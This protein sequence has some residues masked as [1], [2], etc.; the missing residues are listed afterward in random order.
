MEQIQI[1][2]F[3]VE[4][5]LEFIYIAGLHKNA[6]TFAKALGQEVVMKKIRSRYKNHYPEPKPNQK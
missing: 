5:F 2:N 4:E 1:A 3:S 6:E